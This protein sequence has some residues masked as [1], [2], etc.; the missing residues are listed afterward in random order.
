MEIHTV[1]CVGHMH[2]ACHF[3][4]CIRT[5]SGAGAFAQSGRKATFCLGPLPVAM[6]AAVE[7]AFL[8][9]HAAWGWAGSVLPGDGGPEQRGG[10]QMSQERGGRPPTRAEGT[11][12]SGL[13][14]LLRDPERVPDVCRT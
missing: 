3:E 10:G 14:N 5:T 12:S 9:K 2:A 1:A 6:R 13:Q 7:Q 8:Q 4:C 11:R